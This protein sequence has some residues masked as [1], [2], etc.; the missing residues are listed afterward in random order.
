MSTVGTA[1]PIPTRTERGT[2][3]AGVTELGKL[4]AR[5]ERI[6]LPIW[7]YA[8]LV[9]VGGTAYSF[10]K[11]YPN[12][13]SRL[14]FAA[15][16]GKDPALDVLYGK[17][18][19]LTTLGGLTAWRMGVFGSLLL[20]IMSIVTVVRHTRA[21]EEAGRFE[22]VG[23]GAVGRHAPLIAVLRIVLGTQ[24]VLGLLIGAV[25]SAFGMG[26]SGAFLFGLCIAA[27]GW[28]FA[29]VTAITVQLTDFGRSAAGLAF[30]VLG[31][32]YL[33][34]AFGAGS[35]ANGPAWL[36]WLSPI[37]WTEQAQSYAGD[38]W[39]VP[40]LDVAGTAVLVALAFRLARSRD[41]GG[42]IFPARPGPARG[43]ARLRSVGALGWRMHRGSLLG[44]GIGLLLFS[45]VL[46]AIAESI[47]E[48]IGT[49]KQANQ[50][51]QRMGGQHGIV[52]AYLAS[53]MNILGLVVAFYAIQSTVRLRTEETSGRVEPLLATKTARLRWA[54]GHLLYPVAGSALL[55]AVGGLAAGLARGGRSGDLG[56][57]LAP[58]VGAG[59]IQVP[60]VWVAVGL[61]V[62]VYGFAPRATAAVGWSFVGLC[63]LLQELGPLL[64]LSHWVTDVSPFATVPRAPGTAVPAQPLV[65]M[66]AIAA[67]LTAAG[68]IGL[69]RRDLG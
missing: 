11:L 1:S 37:G 56:S 6:R 66:T 9:S 34:R 41:L 49:S 36:T 47:V 59:L 61:T 3:F 4:I 21:E 40:L 53:C 30:S 33:L 43:G 31:A 48:L 69:R 23:A 8:L 57:Q 29:G 17:P 39:W 13:E 42:G 24:L 28:F 32:A 60:A 45:A 18:F 20:A 25:L 14:Q 10:R 15:T 2:A 54:A 50:I 64:Q 63:I 7:C 5:R 26:A 27:C 35:G 19:D 58:L 16:V 51:I 12:P 46:G 52:D 55:L 68:L 44:W 38:K 67:A 62:A 22:L 65:V